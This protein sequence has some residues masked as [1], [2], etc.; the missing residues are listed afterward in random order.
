MTLSA[1]TKANRKNAKRSTGPKSTAGKLTVSKNAVSHGIYMKTFINEGE[2]ARYQMFLD[3]LQREYPSENPIIKAQ[4]ERLAKTK[5]LLDRIQK[6]IDASFANS[7]DTERSDEALMDFLG[8][9]ESQ[10]EVAQK[11]IEGSMTLDKMINVKRTRV[12]SE[13]AHLN[14]ASLTS[15][16]DYLY[17]A[18]IFCKYLVEESKNFEMSIERFIDQIAA[19]SLIHI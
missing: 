3:D 10:R 8:M 12:A 7:E 19:L 11:I 18:P 9:D 6:T 14:L 1:S 2:E 5:T 15:N 17:H 16:D 4:I 13:L